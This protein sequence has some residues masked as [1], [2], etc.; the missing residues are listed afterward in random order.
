MKWQDFIDEKK[1][2]KTNK[3]ISKVKSLIDTSD[4]LIAVFSDIQI[5]EISSSTIFVNYYESLRQIIEAIATLHG[6]NVYSHEAFTSFLS[7]ILK[8]D[9]MSR[10]F[11]RFRLLRNRVN[12]YGEK[13]DIEVSKEAKIDMLDI[14]KKFKDKYLK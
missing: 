11:D 14:I 8:E 9:L 10:K 6:F 12:Y 5:N 13:I 2:K 3:D 1:V 7:E 4:N